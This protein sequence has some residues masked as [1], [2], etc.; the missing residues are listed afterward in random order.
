ML[1]LFGESRPA[2]TLADALLAL[3]ARDDDHASERNGIGFNG[4]DTTWGNRLAGLARAGRLRWRAGEYVQARL[5][6]A[7]YRVQ[8]ASAGLDFD[9]I[10]AE[11]PVRVGSV[12]ASAIAAHPNRPLSAR[13]WLDPAADPRSW[14][15][16][17]HAI[18]EEDPEPDAPQ[19]HREPRREPPVPAAPL[20]PADALTARVTGRCALCGGAI[21][22]GATFAWGTERGSR[23]HV[24]GCEGRVQATGPVLRP[25]PVAD[26]ALIALDLDALPAFAGRATAAAVLGAGGLV[27][28]AL[29]GYE[30]RP[31][32]VA[33]AE[34]I[35]A[36]MNANVHLVAE[37]P[38]GTGKS[39]AYLTAAVGAGKKVIV[40]TAIKALQ[41]QLEQKDAPFLSS[42][43]PFSFAVLKGRSNYLCDWRLEEL[44]ERAAGDMFGV[45]KTL[46]AAEAWP[47]M[48][49]WAAET[50]SG[51]LE[52][53]EGIV[54]AE[55]RELLTVDSDACLSK[56]CPVLAR[57]KVER[58]KRIA[59]A[60]NV[61]IVNHALL[62]RDLM[63]RDMTG[64]NSALLPDE[65]AT[66]VLDEGH[67][68]EDQA[69]DAFGVELSLGTWKRIDRRLQNLTV[70]HASV[71][72]S[73]S[74]AG[75]E[76]AAWHDQAAEL[77]DRA[78]A[79]EGPLLE[80]FAAVEASLAE[81][82]RDA[83][84][85]SNLARPAAPVLAALGALFAPIGEDEVPGWLVKAADRMAW[86]K[87][88]GSADNLATALALLASPAADDAIV[89]FAKWD[90]A[91]DRRRLVLCAKPIDVSGELRRLL[92]SA[93][94][95]IELDTDEAT[96]E[97]RRAR[98]SGYESV[99]AVSATIATD[100]GFT[101]WRSRVGL[102]AAAELMVESP[103]DYDRNALLY[104][105]FGDR[106]AELDPQRA[107]DERSREAYFGAL[108]D[109]MEELVTA[110]GGGAFLLFTSGKAMREVHGR[111]ADRLAR[112]GLLVMMQ[113]DA[114]RGRLVADFKADGHAVL[115]G[116]K[117]FWEGV[118]IQGDALRLVALDKMP[119]NPPDDP[120]YAA[121]CDAVD[122]RAGRQMAWFFGLALPNAVIALKQGFG[123]L[124]RTTSD[125]GVVAILDGRLGSKGYGERVIAALPPARRASRLEPV[126]AFYA[127]D[128]PGL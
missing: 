49:D 16:D 122:R 127:A 37:A 46:E 110:S 61:I 15:A 66:V 74:D 117:T 25:A 119:F 8:L 28:A 6:L 20:R 82:E 41:E 95:Y 17:D 9:L 21:P 114:P 10:P 43:L 59:K 83:L 120:I 24:P 4:S 45:F 102:D 112:A 107:R 52:S 115:F 22:A 65:H 84:P 58:A 87:L 100:A 60:S 51:D 14:S 106:G 30:P 32:Q 47:E 70:Y 126:R 80:L 113:G 123:R 33:L 2:P 99:I 72:A 75:D 73:R 97:I 89:R 76:T 121:R 94:R 42:V 98:V 67:H 124:I 3:S 36:A 103:F 55:L 104:V 91:G 79:V 64:G 108:S 44:R 88:R 63:I 39:L 81:A 78:T 125:R 5:R 109:T 69:T 118:D 23:V 38:T 1:D 48:D 93:P 40:S 34:A 27:S 26:R 13:A 71:K 77:M 29:P 31:S 62:L 85:L 19:P 11:E 105:P 50:V 12:P 35:Q 101:Y 116:L 92:F 111:I 128:G 90:G 68:L 57:C 56:A 53:A 7:K 18:P 54:P 96:G 86:E